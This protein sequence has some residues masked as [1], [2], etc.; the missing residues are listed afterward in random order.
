MEPVEYFAYGANISAAVMRASCPEH[1]FLC[2]ALLDGHRLAFTR[3]SVRT[4]TGVADVVA[5]AGCGVWGALYRLSPGD[6]EQLDRKEGVGFAYARETVTVTDG[7]GAAHG[8][9]VYTVRVKEPVEVA[10]GAAYMRL[11]IDGAR[12]RGL[13]EDYVASLELLNGVWGLG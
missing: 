9:L 11:L 6:L 10:P 4:G 8:A 12:E 1:R 7:D 2:P 5:Q 3:R 13:P